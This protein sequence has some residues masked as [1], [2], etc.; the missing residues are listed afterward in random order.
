MSTAKP[1]ADEFEQLTATKKTGDSKLDKFLSN[2]G[3]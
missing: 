1:A 3:K 2:Y